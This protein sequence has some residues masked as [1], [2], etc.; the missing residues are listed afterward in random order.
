MFQPLTKWTADQKAINATDSNGRI[1]DERKPY[2]LMPS[3]IERIGQKFATD[4]KMVAAPQFIP[5]EGITYAEDEYRRSGSFLLPNGTKVSVGVLFTLMSSEYGSDFYDG[6]DSPGEWKEV[7]PT[8]NSG[9]LPFA[10]FSK[11]IP[12]PPT[13]PVNVPIAEQMGA[14]GKGPGLG[15]SQQRMS[16]ILEAMNR[17]FNLGVK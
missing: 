1:P 4:L 6:V 17:T 5:E 9:Y 3:H 14:T 8:S 11:R 7:T 10:W 13:V 2:Y 12:G 15:M 16:D